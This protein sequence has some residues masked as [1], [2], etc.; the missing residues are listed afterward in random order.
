[1]SARSFADLDEGFELSPDG[2]HLRLSLEDPAYRFTFD[3]ID[4]L[5][6][7]CARPAAASPAAVIDALGA[8]L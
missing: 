1:M 3:K 7:A 5:P 2:R 6:E 4:A 8:Y